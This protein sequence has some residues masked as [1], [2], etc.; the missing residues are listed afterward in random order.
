MGAATYDIFDSVEGINYKALMIKIDS[1]TAADTVTVSQFDTI[2][3]A[4]GIRLDDHTAVICTPALNV[5]TV[6]TGPLTEA[7]LIFCYG[8]KS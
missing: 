7:V 4:Y 5:I 1:C 3:L 8:Y 6:G 2:T